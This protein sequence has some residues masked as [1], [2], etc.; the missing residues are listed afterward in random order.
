MKKW[1]VF[2]LIMDDGSGLL[3]LTFPYS[4]DPNATAKMGWTRGSTFFDT[5]APALPKAVGLIFHSP[6]NGYLFFF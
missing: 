5:Y 2:V 4:V 3:V 6:S 1:G